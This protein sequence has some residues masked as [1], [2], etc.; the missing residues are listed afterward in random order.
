MLLL[1]EATAVDSEGVQG[2]DSGNGDGLNATDG[3]ET[4][5][6]QCS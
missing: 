2:G 6:F 3:Q 4:G 5:D 1:G